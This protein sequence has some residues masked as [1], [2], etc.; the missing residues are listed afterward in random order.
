MSLDLL[1]C[2]L[3]FHDDAA[4]TVLCRLA[5]SRLAGVDVLWELALLQIAESG[6]TR[7][8]RDVECDLEVFSTV[9]FWLRRVAGV[10]VHVHA[11]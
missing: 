11:L 8:C 7:I 4:D 3:S 5:R 10:A 9:F 1:A 6:G 2:F